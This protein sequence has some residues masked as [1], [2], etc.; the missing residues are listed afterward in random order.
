MALWL[1]R[2]GR[3]GEHE[4]RFFGDARIYLTWGDGLQDVDLGSAKDYDDIKR[5][6]LDAYPAGSKGRI[7]DWA[8]QIRAFVLPMKL[9]DWVDVP[10][11]TKAAIAFGEITGPYRYE[12]SVEPL[13][14]HSRTRAHQGRQ[15]APRAI[16]S[17]GQRHLEHTT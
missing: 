15:S 3:S 17:V 12:P 5:L 7:Q 10:R 9:G 2:A 11:K 4:P 1:V 6:V 13:Y 14:C 16:P 8:G